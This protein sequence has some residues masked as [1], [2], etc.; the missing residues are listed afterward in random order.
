[1]IQTAGF[2]A[3]V[4]RYLPEGFYPVG[5]DVSDI[6]SIRTLH[7]LYSDGI[8]TLSLFENA[9]GA[10]VDLSHYH[11]SDAKVADRGAQYVEDGPTRLLTWTEESNLHYAL[12]GELSRS[13]L[14]RIANSVEP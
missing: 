7:L 5:G 14:V 6:K 10:A 9:R 11:I 2:K 8:R 1:M 13:E 12:I 3:R 4:P